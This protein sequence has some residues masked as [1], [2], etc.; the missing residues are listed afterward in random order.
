MFN[1]AKLKVK[2]GHFRIYIQKKQKG[3]KRAQFWPFLEE[4][5]MSSP[6]A[7]WIAKSFCKMVLQILSL[8]VVELKKREDFKAK[9]L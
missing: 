6:E 3:Q 5:L 7:I 1:S 4:K 9:I 2:Q 8:G